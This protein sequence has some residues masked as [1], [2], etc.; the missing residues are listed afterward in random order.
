M[1]VSMTGILQK[2]R[3]GHYGVIAPNICNED[4]ARAAI[5]VAAETNSPII[6]DVIY[7]ASPDITLLA[8]EVKYL[9]GK[10]SVPVALNLDHGGEFSQHMEAIRAGFSSIMVDR[11]SE[12]YDQNVAEVSE[13]VKIAHTCGMSVEA[14]LG[15]V[16][17]G[18]NYAVDGV[19][20]L[21][22][23]T[24]A[25]D[26]V[27]ATGIDALA[28][29]IGTAHGPYKGTPHIDFDRLHEVYDAVE[30][31]LVLHGGSGSGD[32]NIARAAREGITKINVGTDLF[33]AGMGNLAEHHTELKRANLGYKLIS[34]AYKD[35]LLH[36]MQLVNQ[37]GKAE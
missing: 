3:E 10:V 36:Y 31:P 15:H 4:T 24:Q 22:D 29:A 21:T 32:E 14:E 20:A 28:I 17:I 13:L 16:G 19:T 7:G 35:K 33:L 27:E 30:I 25:R 8:Q 2:S 5:E 23:P 12:P 37:V 1:L 11:S 6:L 9:A 34:D 26:Y 18:E